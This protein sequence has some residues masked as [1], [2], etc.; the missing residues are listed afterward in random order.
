MTVLE[1]AVLTGRPILLYDGVCGL[2]N[3]LVR[4]FLRL[5][6]GSVLFFAP[7]ESPL[8]L[9]FLS[10]FPGLPT[11]SEGITLITHALTPQETFY[12][13]SEAIAEALRYLGGI[14]SLFGALLLFIP[15][16]LREAGYGTVARNRYRIFGKFDTC[17]IPT[18]A[19][20]SRILG[21]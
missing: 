4:F 13:R 8:A 11:D 16:F 21:M 5:D 15:R 12:H 3:R 19:Q 9:E 17:P 7:L 10:R 2:C 20:R 1:Q 14:W 18:E 6:S